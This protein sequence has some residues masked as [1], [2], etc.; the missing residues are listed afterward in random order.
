MGWMRNPGRCAGLLYLVGSIPGF[1][2]L[3]YVPSRVIV[4]GNPVATAHNIAAHETLFR[5]GIAADLAGQAIFLFV[6]LALYH[7]LKGVNRRLA[8]MMLLLL[9]VSIPI[10][11]VNEL[12]SMAALTF[13]KGAEFLAGFDEAQRVAWM[14]VFL[15]LRG[16]G[17]DIAGIFWGLWLFPLGLLVYRSEFIPRLLGV[18]LM[19]G[20]FAYLAN[21]FTS[22][23]VPQYEDLV[24][25]W[26]SP[27]QLVE[28]VFMLWLVVMGEVPKTL[29][30]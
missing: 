24:S 19:V 7:L 1:F 12:N 16:T 10:A 23:A 22:L 15:N 9:V 18:G 3:L 4:H 13:A 5:M 27:V 26:V 21:S 8:L 20:C 25:R 2:A 28:M 17:F 14:R 30:D 29:P 6:A 11:F